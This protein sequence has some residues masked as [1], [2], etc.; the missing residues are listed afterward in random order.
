MVTG[1]SIAVL[2]HQL[3]ELLGKSDLMEDL[4][5]SPDVVADFL[6][7]RLLENFFG[8]IAGGRRNNGKHI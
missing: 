5:V 4:G 7:M 2:R 1:T 3:E 6:I 8:G